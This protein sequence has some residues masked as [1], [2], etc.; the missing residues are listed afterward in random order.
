MS[1]DFE[2]VFLLWIFGSELLLRF[3]MKQRQEEKEMA[4][5]RKT[6]IAALAVIALL[7][8]AIAVMIPTV[9]AILTSI[10]TIQSNGT[11]NLYHL[12]FHLI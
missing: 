8:V 2:Y 9:L 4:L 5:Q 10:K 1:E 3:K 12:I 6:A 7:I 11:I